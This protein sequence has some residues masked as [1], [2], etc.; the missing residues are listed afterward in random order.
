MSFSTAKATS[1][2][3]SDSRI[4]CHLGS[5]KGESDV[6]INITRP[7]GAELF[8]SA[9]G[10]QLKCFNKNLL[11]FLHTGKNCRLRS[12]NVCVTLPILNLAQISSV[13][14]KV[15]LL[16]SS[17]LE[18]SGW[19][20]FSKWCPRP[21]NSLKTK[22]LKS[23][24]RHDDPEIMSIS[25]IHVLLLFSAIG[26]IFHRPFCRVCRSCAK[27]AILKSSG[28]VVCKGTQPR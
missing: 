9:Y 20:N 17:L 22:Q 19:G 4:S 12:S 7:R 26:F 23:H 1:S 10:D 18:K 3:F 25:H 5:D 8:S 11:Q 6:A 15:L 27:L 21:V 24:V 2:A 13:S 14:T 16:S 28:I